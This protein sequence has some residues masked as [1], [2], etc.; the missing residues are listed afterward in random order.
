MARYYLTG[1]NTL[2]FLTKTPGVLSAAFLIRERTAEIRGDA[3][4]ES[5]FFVLSIY[6]RYR[7]LQAE[8]AQDAVDRIP[9][10]RIVPRRGRR[11]VV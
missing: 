10:L 4:P 1:L 5:V 3:D 9:Y 2:R 8:Y 7:T 11:Q 6:E